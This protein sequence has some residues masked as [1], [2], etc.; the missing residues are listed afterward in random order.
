M[1]DR[2]TVRRLRDDQGLAF[3]VVFKGAEGLATK[4]DIVDK[5]AGRSRHP[6]AT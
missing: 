1:D 6:A 5:A 2:G 3:N 4:P